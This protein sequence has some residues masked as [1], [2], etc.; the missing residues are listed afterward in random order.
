MSFQNY[1]CSACLSKFLISSTLLSQLLVI[2]FTSRNPFLYCAYIFSSCF[3]CCLI[4]FVISQIVS[5]RVFSPFDRQ[6]IHSLHLAFSSSFAILFCKITPISRS[7]YAPSSFSFLHQLNYPLSLN[8]SFSALPEKG[9][10]L[11]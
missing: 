4:S 5:C 2:F 6:C 7:P 10:E 1:L 8:L 3:H 11:Y 9:L